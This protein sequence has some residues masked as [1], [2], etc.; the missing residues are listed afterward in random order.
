M[1]RH[2][3]TTL[4]LAGATL[5]LLPS[6]TTAAERTGRI[7]GTVY[8]DEGTPMGGATVSVS[9][10]TQIGGTR[11]TTSNEDGSFRFIGLIPGEFKLRTSKKGFRTD[12]RQGIRINVNKTVTLDILLDKA[13]DAAP[14]KPKPGEQAQAGRRSPSP[15]PA[16]EPGAP[17]PAEGPGTETYVITA[18]RPVVDV[19]KATTGESL[20]DE[21]VESVPLS[22]RSYQGVAGM[23]GR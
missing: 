5:L 2:L 4:L 1:T 9:S 17:V 12:V 3:I 19:T 23:T 18:A 20:S 15:A 11:V 16:D 8:D 14:P 7:E 22:G 13:P 21:Y 10:P 6:T